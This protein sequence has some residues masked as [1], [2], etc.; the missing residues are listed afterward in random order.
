MRVV[1]CCDGDGAGPLLAFAF[2][3]LA[4]VTML[5]L[6]YCIDSGCQEDVR[7]AQGS[8]LGRLH[9]GEGHDAG[10]TA[11]AEQHA[12]AVLEEAATAARHAGYDGEQVAH[13]VHGRP[14]HEI[15]QA[16]GELRADV[17]V[18]FPRPPARQVPP[19]PHSLGHAARFI[20]DHAPCGVLL[21]RG[22]I[23]F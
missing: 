13:V 12:A 3:H 16:L 2:A 4:P 22:G 7:L 10:L 18:L 21:V 15:V 5:D 19:G 17:V 6:L 8:F 23:S 11:A 20:V 9:R 14:G 1:C